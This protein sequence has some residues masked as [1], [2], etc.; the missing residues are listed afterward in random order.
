MD[1]RIITFFL[2]CLLFFGVGASC[3]AA[4]GGTQSITLNVPCT[5]RLAVGPHGSVTVDGHEYTGDGSFHAG[6]GKALS[7]VI[8]PAGGYVIEKLLVNGVDRTA[9]VAEG[10]FE[11]GALEGNMT[12]SVTFA[13]KAGPE[14]RPPGGGEKPVPGVPP[15]GT[16]G[17]SNP[18][19]GAVNAAGRTYPLSPRTG[20]SANVGAWAVLM[21]LSGTLL[22]V[23]PLI[24]GKHKRAGR[25]SDNPSE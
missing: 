18:A 17:N 22:A 7:F 24:S 14:P 5:V 23:I 2:C 16:D 15:A 11:A 10:V 12:V 8:K 25:C 9:A 13:K 19:S 1:K 6:F 20:D 3:Y 4:T 21:L